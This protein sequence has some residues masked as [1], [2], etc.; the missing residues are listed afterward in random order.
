M[1]RLILIFGLAFTV[2]P[3]LRAER[4][5]K[6][7]GSNH[8]L[9]LKD[10]GSVWGFGNCTEGQLGPETENC[11]FV[12]SPRQIGLPGKAI[13]IAVGADTSYALLEGGAVYAWGRDIDAQLGTGQPFAAGKNRPNRPTP[14]P[15]VGLSNVVRIYASGAHALA[16]QP[17][18]SVWTWGK[19]FAGGTRDIP[20]VAPVRVAHLPPIESLS[21]SEGHALALARNGEVY[22]WGS[23]SHGQLGD[24]TVNASLTPVRVAPLPSAVSVAAGLQ[25]S[26]AA[27]VDG[28]VRVWGSNAAANMGNGDRNAEWSD[29]GGKYLAPTAVAG[30]TGAKA[31]AANDGT[32]M[33]LLKDGTVR[34]WGHDGFGQAG[35]G[36][37]GGYQPKPVRT[38]LTGVAGLFLHKS[39]C[40]AVTNSGQLYVW[41]FGHYRLLGPM[42]DNLKVPTLFTSP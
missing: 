39:T 18:G 4:Y 33:A 15:V 22:G 37:S 16:L 20:D 2:A 30:V 17:D 42:K 38:K 34:A 31:V 7:A 19:S 11:R 1:L 3:S 10:D 21:L 23:N 40:F 8:F 32:V 14:G 13:D 6:E 28:T 24:G 5:L 25:F 9:F 35:F 41:G 36:T 12:R 29:P 26:V 27:L